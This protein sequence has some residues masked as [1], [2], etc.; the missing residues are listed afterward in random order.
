MPLERMFSFFDPPLIRYTFKITVPGASA[1]GTESLNRERT[2]QARF[3]AFVFFL[4]LSLLPRTGALIF[5]RFDFVF[6]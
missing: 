5:F 4:S 3:L 6:T 1:V 2:F